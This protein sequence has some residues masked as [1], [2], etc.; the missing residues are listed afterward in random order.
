MTVHTASKQ[1]TLTPL[2]AAV[3]ADLHPRLA[4]ETRLCSTLADQSSFEAVGQTHGALLPNKA[5]I[6]DDAALAEVEQLQV[7]RPAVTGQCIAPEASKGQ[8][9]A[10]TPVTPE[11]A[12]QHTTA[13]GPDEAPQPSSDATL[14]PACNSVHAGPANTTLELPQQAQQ[15]AQQDTH[16]PVDNVTI[17]ASRDARQQQPEGIVGALQRQESSSMVSLSPSLKLDIPGLDD[18]L[19]SDL[20]TEN[21]GQATSHLQQAS[22]HNQHDGNDH[23]HDQQHHQQSVDQQHFVDDQ[24]QQQQQLQQQPVDQHERKADQQQEI[25]Q[26]GECPA[27]PEASQGAPDDRNALQSTLPA[28]AP[29]EPSSLGASAKGQAGATASSGQGMPC[30]QAEV[31]TA[32]KPGH[33]RSDITA[34]EGCI[35]DGA[36]QHLLAAESQGPSEAVI[37]SPA[38]YLALHACEGGSAAE[39][40][41]SLPHLAQHLPSG[42]M[43]SATVG[44][45]GDTDGP[46]KSAAAANS[47]SAAG[48]PTLEDGVQASDSCLA[49]SEHVPSSDRDSMRLQARSHVELDRLPTTEAV[50]TAQVSAATKLHSG[51]AAH[52]P[53]TA[54]GQRAATD[55]QPQSLQQISMTGPQQ[56]C[57]LVNR[58]PAAKCTL[59]FN[60]NAANILQWHLGICVA[61]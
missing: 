57:Q 41:D 51:S 26:R 22:Q 25:V 44:T 56:V 31:Q 9:H 42:P 46:G 7:T 2:L 6:S 12:Q 61:T 27:G 32:S 36:W 49:S 17:T 1:T 11:S 34:L 40:A 14:A 54:A 59:Y 38:G 37:Q 43:D 58:A 5:A 60:V 23:H 19:S 13:S 20:L 3:E 16:Y 48:H 55:E 50:V 24:Q 10:E 35:A 4:L 8:H 18:I 52:C 15:E 28:P 45:A 39:Q 53:A 47:H 33:P 21:G 30:Q 29:Q